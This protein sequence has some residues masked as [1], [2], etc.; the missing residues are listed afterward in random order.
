M[1]YK[2]RFSELYYETKIRVILRFI[3]VLIGEQI[4]NCFFY[5]WGISLSIFPLFLLIFAQKYLP[6]FSGYLYFILS[7]LVYNTFS[8]FSILTI[9][10]IHSTAYAFACLTD[11][12]KLSALLFLYTQT[13]LLCI[14]DRRFCVLQ[15][16]IFLAIHTLFIAFAKL[17]IV[18][19]KAKKKESVFL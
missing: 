18:P 10:A 9:L 8:T 3:W 7:I 19:P 14:I 11:F 5:S 2:Y 16:G 6:T 17:D 1:S 4:L 15:V 12:K 13:G